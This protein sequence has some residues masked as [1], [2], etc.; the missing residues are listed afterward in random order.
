LNSDNAEVRIEVAEALK[1]MDDTDAL[2]AL[3]KTFIDVLK[4]LAKLNMILNLV[5]SSS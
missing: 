2:E 4:F 1:D 3:N 5:K